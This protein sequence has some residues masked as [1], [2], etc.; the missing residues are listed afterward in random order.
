VG[1][2]ISIGT[3]AIHR[4]GLVWVK[5]EI[6]HAD[7]RS[8]IVRQAGNELAIY[9]FTYSEQIQGSMEHIAET[10]GYQY[11]DH[12]KIQFQPGQFVALKVRGKPSK[13]L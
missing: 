10:G 11:G 9:T 13:P 4:K 1:P 6:V 7:A 3:P 8:M 5:A 12:V 2:V